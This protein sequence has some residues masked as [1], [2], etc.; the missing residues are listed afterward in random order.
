[1]TNEELAEL[2]K[3]SKGGKI[4]LDNDAWWLD[5][6]E[7]RPVAQGHEPPGQNLLYSLAEAL[8]IETEMC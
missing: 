3:K 8:G 4:T 2:L 7:G 5:D 6:K 1:M